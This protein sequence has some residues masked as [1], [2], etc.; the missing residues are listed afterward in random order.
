MSQNQNSKLY[1]LEERTFQFVKKTTFYLKDL[2]KS[3]SNLKYS[4]QV[5]VTLQVQL[6]LITSKPTKL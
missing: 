3:V 4:R 2:P 6:V 1:E 5:I